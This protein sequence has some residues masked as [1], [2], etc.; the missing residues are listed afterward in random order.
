M[1]KMVL[2]P[3]FGDTDMLGHINNVALPRW[4]EAAREPVF[5]LFLPDLPSATREKWPLVLVH[6]D[7]DFHAELTYGQDV[8]IR[9]VVTGVGTTS[10]C[11]RHEAWQ[12]GQLRGS[13]NVVMVHYDFAAGAKVPV[14]SHIRQALAKHRAPEQ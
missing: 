2:S 12:D 3:R 9:T 11:L 13:G 14:P 7:F 8:E 5:R 4:F 10:I 6:M 1:F